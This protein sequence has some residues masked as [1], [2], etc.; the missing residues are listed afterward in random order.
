MICGLLSYFHELRGCCCDF[1]RCALVFDVMCSD[2]FVTCIDL[3][4]NMYRAV[5][6]LLFTLLPNV[7]YSSAVEELPSVVAG[8]CGVSAAGSGRVE[9]CSLGALQQRSG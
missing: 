9:A 5:C 6:E 3:F 1:E 2:L 8:A 7:P 4:V